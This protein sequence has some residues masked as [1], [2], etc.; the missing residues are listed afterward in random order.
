VPFDGGPT[1]AAGGTTSLLAEGEGELGAVVVAVVAAGRGRD[2][3]AA[4]TLRACWDVGW[5]DNAR[6]KSSPIVRTVWQPVISDSPTATVCVIRPLIVIM[7][8][9]TCRIPAS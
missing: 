6:E 5:D 4:A 9:N 2:A 8:P 1:G 3:G 7:Y